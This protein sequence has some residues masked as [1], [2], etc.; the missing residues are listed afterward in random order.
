MKG[1]VILLTGATDG[2]GAVAAHEL[3]RLGATVVAVGR[4]PDKT[5]AVVERIKQETSNLQ[6]E[7][8]VADLSSQ[9]DIHRLARQFKERHPRLDVLLN[10]A[11]A[12]FH[13][14]RRSVDGIEM[15]FALNHLGYFL[16]THLLLDLLKA[17]APS[18]I[19]NTSSGAH[20]RVQM[21]F[22]DLQNEHDY[23]AMRVY[24]QSKL[25]NL[26]FTYELARRLQGTGV[27]VN[28]F[29]PGV[30][31]TRFGAETGWVGHLIR[32]LVWPFTIT[33]EKGARTLVHLAT[34]P[35][36]AHVT[37]QYFYKNQVIASS[38][39]SHDEAAARRLWEVSESLT[40]RTAPTA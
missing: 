26:L 33:P 15:T 21:N 9:Q 5:A 31:M 7:G 34:A 29:H 22:D 13:P 12:V 30:V 27:T 4:N 17:S 28:A 2:I 11:G 20:R 16:L 14:R 24:S 3:A 40:H 39:V 19:V 10:N 18:R 25:A 36:L 6:V 37:G 23:R 1:K 38:V 8:L 32:A 35:E